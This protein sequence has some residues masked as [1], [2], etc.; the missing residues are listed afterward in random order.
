MTRYIM[1]AI[2]VAVLLTT[3]SI[4]GEPPLKI[5]TFEADVTPPIGTP[6]CD[7]LV[8]PAKEIVDPLSARGIILFTS[9]KPIVLVAVDWVGIGNSGHHAFREVIGKA[10]GTTKER[11]CVHCLHQ[12]DAP[13]CDFEADEL[14]VP[15]KLGGKLFDPIFANKAIDRI[16][17]AVAKAAKNP[18]TVT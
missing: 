8:V 4:A 2:S 9:E 14:L 1:I 3:Q 12:H 15:Y 13:G 7:G 5:A 6:L 16:A 11:V 10:A 17:K 18:Q